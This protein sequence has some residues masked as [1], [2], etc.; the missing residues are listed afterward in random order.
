MLRKSPF[1]Y[2]RTAVGL[3]CPTSIGS[4]FSFMD[5]EDFCRTRGVL[6]DLDD[7]DFEGD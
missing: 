4:G 1:P 5:V 6:V 7:D 2:D 3:P